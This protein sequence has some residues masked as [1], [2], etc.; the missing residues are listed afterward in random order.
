[1]SDSKR[2]S[3]PSGSELVEYYATDSAPPEYVPG[4]SPGDREAEEQTR[5]RS[6]INLAADYLVRMCDDNG[7]FVYR[8]HSQARVRFPPRYNILRH[9]GAMFAL[10]S[11]SARYRNRRVHE[12]LG[13]TANFLKG[14]SLVPLPAREDLLAVWSFSEITHVKEPDQARLGATGLGLIALTSIE[15][16]SRGYTPLDDLKRMGNFLLFMQQENG[17]FDSKFVPAA[18]GR[19]GKWVSLYYPGEAALGLLMLYELDRNP[20]WFEAA[21]MAI[22]FLAKIRSGKARVEADHW[23]LLATAKLLEI[24]NEQA[25]ALSRY[26]F[27][28]HAIQI[29]ESILARAGESAAIGPDRGCMTGDGRTCPTAT[30]LE[31]LQAALTFLPPNTHDLRTRISSAVADGIQFLLRSQVTSGRYAGGFPR[32]VRP[33]PNDLRK[34]DY[35]FNLRVKEIRIDYVQHALSAMMQFERLSQS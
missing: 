24:S 3:Q 29:C 35:A 14:K 5:L 20:K 27:L 22:A 10:A 30:R 16:I 33:M 34:A 1:M 23:V 28:Q 19:T 6:G 2:E 32:G 26:R 25:P 31:G 4:P 8:A 18:G 11:Y 7:R 15:R 21:A 12:I 17:S 13:R 9:A